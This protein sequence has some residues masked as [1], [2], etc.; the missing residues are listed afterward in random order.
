MTW[1]DVALQLE[2]DA[3]AYEAIVADADAPLPPPWSPAVV[4]GPPPAAL[5]GRL[6]AALARLQAAAGAL[7]QAK[8]RKADELAGL[9]R[10]TELVSRYLD[11]TA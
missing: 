5:H 7:A 9:S 11:T 2:L 4:A 3:A 8:A 10:P 1:V 6:N